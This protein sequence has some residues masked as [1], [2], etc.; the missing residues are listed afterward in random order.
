MQLNNGK[1]SHLVPGD[2]IHHLPQAGEPARAERL[3]ALQWLS[4]LYYTLRP[5]RRQQ[6]IYR[7]WYPVYKRFYRPQEATATALQ[8]ARSW[9][10]WPLFP[11]PAF[12]R[13]DP[14]A[15]QFRLLHT[16]QAYPGNIDWNDTRHGL[17]WTYH[18]NYFGWLNDT[19]MTVEGRHQT[20]R[21][22]CQAASVLR[23]GLDSYPIS[24]RSMNWIRFF[25]GEGI[26][27]EAANTVLYS[28]CH[29]LLHFP[30]YHLQGNH[31]WENGCALFMAGVYFKDHPFYHKGTVLLTR[32]LQEQVLPDGGHI[33][34]SPM[35]HSLLLSHLLQCI[36]LDSERQ[37]AGL[38]ALMRE[39]AALMLGWLEVMSFTDGSVAQVGDSTGGVAPSLAVLRSFATQLGIRTQKVQLRESG[40]RM[41]RMGALECLVDAG[42]IQPAYQP[43]HAHADTFSFCLFAN[44]HPVLVD[45]GCSTYETGPRR[46]RERS[47]D[48]HNTVCINGEN[49]TDVWKGFRTGKK[50][51]VTILSEKEDFIAMEH[52][53]YKHLGVIH[54]RTYTFLA[55]KIIVYDSLNSINNKIAVLNLHL[56]PD[57]AFKK[58]RDFDFLAG[59]LLIKIEHA[60]SAFIE[61]YSYAQEFNKT[62]PAQRLHIELSSATLITIENST[63]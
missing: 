48:F 16:A 35:Y 15:R 17:L 25:I 32:A 24:L 54:Q 10:Q 41:F 3:T 38:Q 22:Y 7:I 5:L 39:K 9:P 33:E 28:H 45:P 31:L 53:G 58:I 44:G 18:L 36:E 8:A 55:N 56:H 23:V 63:C 30:E 26:R 13:Y 19:G 46:N 12:D 14:A 4:R 49:S 52:N 62:V 60:Q 37:D 50:A 27:D 29:R 11:L 57:M 40:Y 51:Q 6:Y 20:I 34:G 42:N 47:T 43:G 1:T 61:P 59:N 2:K 21:V